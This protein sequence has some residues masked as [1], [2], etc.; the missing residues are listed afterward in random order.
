MELPPTTT[1]FVRRFIALR[2]HDSRLLF[3]EKHEPQWEPESKK[4]AEQ[5]QL[6]CKRTSHIDNPGQHTVL[7]LSVCA[8]QVQCTSPRSH[9]G[10]HPVVRD[11]RRAKNQLDLHIFFISASITVADVED[12]TRSSSIPEHFRPEWLQN[13]V[14]KALMWYRPFRRQSE[15]LLPCR[16]TARKVYRTIPK[17]PRPLAGV[18]VDAEVNELSLGFFTSQFF[19]SRYYSTYLHSAA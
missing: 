5:R 2:D 14:S 12:S 3:G 17:L 9:S 13:N 18:Q 16:R 8:I 4:C 15:L 19:A 6:P 7:F 10:E 11:C 1:Y